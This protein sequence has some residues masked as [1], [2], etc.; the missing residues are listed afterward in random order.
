MDEIIFDPEDEDIAKHSFGIKL[1][2]SEGIRYA[3][4]RFKAS[5]VKF[6]NWFPHR[7]VLERKLGRKLHFW[8]V[9]DHID[10]NGLN[11]SRDNIRAITHS[12]NRMNSKMNRNNTSGY[13]GVCKFGDCY[14]MAQINIDGK[15]AYLGVY[16]T[17]EEA[18]KVYLKKYYEL[19]K[20]YPPEINGIIT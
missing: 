4:F 3:I 6:G 11:N 13:R 5:F 15:R 8:E 17:P 14:W 1:S 20:E 19:Y 18:S 10:R 16:D 9:P 2:R 7:A 12:M